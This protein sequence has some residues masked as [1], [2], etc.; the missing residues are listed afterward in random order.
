MAFEWFCRQNLSGQYQANHSSSWIAEV[1]FV[2]WLFWVISKAQSQ[3]EPHQELTNHYCPRSP[4]SYFLPMLNKLHF[5]QAQLSISGYLMSP[6]ADG[7]L[8]QQHLALLRLQ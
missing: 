6:C 2:H 4:W 7:Y 3:Y 5:L 8:L 1:K